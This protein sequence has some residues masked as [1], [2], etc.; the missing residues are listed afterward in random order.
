MT[1]KKILKTIDQMCIESLSP[2]V[3][4]KWE[5]VRTWLVKTRKNLEKNK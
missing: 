4:K 2:E 5:D 3:F 1:E